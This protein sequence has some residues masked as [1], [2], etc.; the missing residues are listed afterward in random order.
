MRK[1]DF[2]ARRSAFR[3]LHD[4]GCFVI[5]NPWDTGSA[6]LLAHLGFEAL[7]TTSS[8]FA[9][10]RGRPDNAM[11]L[12]AVLAHFREVVEATGLPVNADFEDGH[13]R[14]LDGLK[15]NVHRCIETGVAGLSIEDATGDASQP[16]YALDEA[17][18]RMRAAREAIDESGE[19]VLLIGRAECFLTGHSDP[20]NESLKRL[21]A[22]AGAGADCLYAPGLRTPEQIEAV[23]QAVAPKPVNVLVG[24]PAPFTLDDLAG[25]GVRRISVGSA[26][27]G[28]AWGGFLRAARGLAEGRF[29]GFA[30][31]A[32]YAELNRLF[33]GS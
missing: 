14:D 8:G 12:D 23:V 16:L 10:S 30:D 28:A 15:K 27:A 9:W 17:V 13:A 4:S 2:S 22:Y 32:A 5:P 33:A 19:D 3:K 29:D 1:P 11:P 24:W 18:A 25:L 21:K 31:N 6:K 7:A 26:L 20:L